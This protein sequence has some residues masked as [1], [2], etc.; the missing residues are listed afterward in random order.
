MT[1]KPCSDWPQPW[2]ALA[3][4]DNASEADEL[5]QVVIKRWPASP[6]A[7]PARAARTAL[8]HKNMRGKVGGGLRPDVMMYIAGAL[9]TFAKL[10]VAKRQQVTLEIALKGQ[11]GLDINDAEAKYT[12][13]SLPGQFS[14]MHLV[15]IMYVGMKELDPDTDS[16]VD[17]SAEYEAAKLMQNKN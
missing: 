11:T 4:E 10:D 12:L 14:G 16:G 15:S 17:L 8:A 1:R 9:D 5:Y 13:K 3:G 2:R 6:V 7:E